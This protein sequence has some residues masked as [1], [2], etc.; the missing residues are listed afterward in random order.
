MIRKM[1]LTDVGQVLVFDLG[2]PLTGYTAVVAIKGP[3]QFVWSE[4]AATIA[5]HTVGYTVP[6]SVF[7]TK[8]LWLVRA[9]VT[10]SGKRFSGPVAELEVTE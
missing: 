10:K 2:I 8:G 1:Q 4:Y 3:Q 5:G 9:I 7:T 6:A